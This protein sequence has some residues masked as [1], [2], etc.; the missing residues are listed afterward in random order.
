MP[1]RAL[2][3]LA[4][5]CCATTAHT[6]PNDAVE[7]SDIEPIDFDGAWTAAKQCMHQGLSAEESLKAAA[8]VLS[9][10]GR[11]LFTPIDSLPGCSCASNWIPADGV[12]V[13]QHEIIRTAGWILPDVSSTGM[14]DLHDPLPEWAHEL[15][16][17]LAPALDG[18]VPN[19]CVVHALEP[20]QVCQ[21]LADVEAAEMLAGAAVLSMASA[22]TLA[23]GGSSSGEECD[24][25]TAVDLEPRSIVLLRGQL[26]HPLRVR[27]LYA[28]HL[29]VTF[30][31]TSCSS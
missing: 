22:G 28:R 1:N 10:E 20:G 21:I 2:L 19:R 24:S 25:C 23:T 12:S 11:G 4:L 15:A 8:R 13:L 29:S 18:S 16:L 30:W 17:R 14:L 6:S 26:E 7:E 5:L 3:G 9:G 31:R 27:S